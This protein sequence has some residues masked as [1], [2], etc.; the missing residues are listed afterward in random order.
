MEVKDGVFSFPAC[1]NRS[2]I[3]AVILPYLQQLFG[4]SSELDY[5]Q[6]EDQSLQPVVGKR[7][8]ERKKLSSV[9][10]EREEECGICLE[11]CTKMV[12][13]NCCHVMCIKCYHDW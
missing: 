4:Y 7:P 13:P 10:L 12:L 3:A 2:K 11:P 8:E 9:N 1:S 5:T 6:K